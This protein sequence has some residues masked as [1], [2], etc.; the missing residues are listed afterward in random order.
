MI[1]AKKSK[2]AAPVKRKNFFN[3]PFIFA[4]MVITIIAVL[5]KNNIP[6]MVEI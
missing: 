3:N 4:F 2:T 5:H 1:L 6:P